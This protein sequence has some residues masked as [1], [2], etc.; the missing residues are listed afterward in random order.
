MI[1]ESFGQLFKYV[2]IQHQPPP[3][4]EFIIDNDSTSRR[5]NTVGDELKFNCK[6]I[7]QYVFSTFPYRLVGWVGEFV[8]NHTFFISYTEFKFNYGINH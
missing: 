1:L 4:P 8:V 3:P 6:Q 7:H 5:T 2:E